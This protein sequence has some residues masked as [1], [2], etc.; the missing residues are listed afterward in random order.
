MTDQFPLSLITQ[1]TTLTT[2]RTDALI[3]LTDKLITANAVKG[4]CQMSDDELWAWWC[5]L[6]DQ[7]RFLLLFHGLHLALWEDNFP[8]FDP[9]YHHQANFDWFNKDLVWKHLIALKNLTNLY[10]HCNEINDLSPL[11]NLTQLIELYLWGNCIT[12][13]SPLSNLKKL[14]E[15]NL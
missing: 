5:G 11:A 9:D 3:M 14:N 15:L 13:L 12:D 10:L 7:W 6:E 8:D 4:I 1:S 2:R